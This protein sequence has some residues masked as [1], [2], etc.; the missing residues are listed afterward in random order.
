LREWLEKHPVDPAGTVFLGN[1]IND[2]PCFPLVSCA[3]A[4]A[5]AHPEVLAQADRVLRR[6]GGQGAVREL[7]ELVLKIGDSPSIP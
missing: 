5:D 7:C 2:L 3:V 4:V 6:D 1:D